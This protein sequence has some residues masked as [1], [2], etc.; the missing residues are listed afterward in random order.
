[1]PLRPMMVPSLLWLAAA[2]PGCAASP[3]L[4]VAP[5]VSRVGLPT[6]LLAC[7]PAPPVPDDADLRTQRD[8]LRF[9]DA[10]WEAGEDCRARLG[11]VRDLVRGDGDG[12]P[13]P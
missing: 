12:P 13:R 6:E 8:W 9:T 3:P 2:L 7:R 4:V 5:T 11:T 10:L 1:M